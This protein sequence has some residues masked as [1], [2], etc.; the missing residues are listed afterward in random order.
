MSA[1]GRVVRAGGGRRRVQ[2]AVTVV[3]TLISV[4]AAILAA[5]L[6][7]ASSAPF[8]SAFARQPGARRAGQFGGRAVT[9]AK[10]AATAEASGVTAAAGPF[11]TVAVPPRSGRGS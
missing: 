10:R 11:P 3:T 1:L 8:D 6:L 9:A 5:G 7:V 2:T 4:T